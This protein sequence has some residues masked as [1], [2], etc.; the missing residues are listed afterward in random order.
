M[1]PFVGC[2]DMKILHVTPSFGLGGMEK[3]ITVFI[4][5]SVEYTHV[6]MPLDGNR[7]AFKWIRAKTA[8]CIEFEKPKSRIIFFIKLYHMIK[9][10]RPDLIMSYSWGGIDALWI[11]RIAKV[12]LTIH[13]E[14]GFNIDEARKTSGKRDL[15]RII[16][17]RL[18]NHIIVV[19]S[20]LDVMLKTKYRL[21]NESI[22][23][24]PNGINTDEFCPSSGDRERIRGQLGFA[25]NDTVVVYCGRLDPVK[26]FEFMLEVIEY[27]GSIDESIRLMIIGD[28]VERTH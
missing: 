16:L 26:N 4:N 21:K 24:I 1:V 11:G 6:I 9:S 17:Y 2:I 20:D 13:N 8:S 28:G 25:E 18:A 23:F 7:D 3:I 12:G 27:C 10:L 5:R 19:S 14:H 15:L 22:S